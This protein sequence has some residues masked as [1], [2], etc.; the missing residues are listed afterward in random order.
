MGSSTWGLP[1]HFQI[2]NLLPAGLLSPEEAGFVRV[3]H[4]I[5]K[6]LCAVSLSLQ[7]KYNT[8]S[9]NQ[10]NPDQGMASY[11]D[12]LIKVPLSLASLGRSQF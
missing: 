7:P 9:G 12:A 5:S 8:G 4:L 10:W 6:V 1:T 2:G 11:K 3:G